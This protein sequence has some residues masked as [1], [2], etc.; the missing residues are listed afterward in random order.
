LTPEICRGLSEQVYRLRPEVSQSTLKNPWGPAKEPTDNMINGTCLHGIILEDR[1]VFTVDEACKTQ[2]NPKQPESGIILSPHNAAIVEGMAAGI[3]RNSDAVLLL[4]SLIEREVS[5]FWDGWKARL[6]GVCPL[7][8]L[9]LKSCKDASRY[10]FSRAIADWEYH[11]QGAQYLEAAAVAHFPCENFWFIAVENEFPFLCAVY[12]LEH[13]SLIIGRRVL[14]EYRERR[15]KYLET[16][17]IPGYPTNQQP[18]GLPG[19]KIKEHLMK[20]EFQ[21]GENNE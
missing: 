5:I 1:R 15:K 9:D 7:G 21:Q 2:K 8:V 10:G 19:W 6:D 17:E 12:P 14:A 3:R 11:V 4:E 16:G 13:E 20:Y 18:I